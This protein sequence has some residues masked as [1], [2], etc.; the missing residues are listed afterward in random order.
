MS[1]LVNVEILDPSTAVDK[2]IIVQSVMNE[3]GAEIKMK[4]GD[5]PRVTERR[6]EIY[7]ADVTEKLFAAIGGVCRARPGRKRRYY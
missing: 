7:K 1:H 3:H 2:A 5:W 6:P 4:K